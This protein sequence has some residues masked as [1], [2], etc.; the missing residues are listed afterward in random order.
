MSA[1]ERVPGPSTFTVTSIIDPGDGVC[2]A[3][4]CTL[5]EAIEAANV[6]PG[7]EEIVFNIP[8]KW[9]ANGYTYSRPDPYCWAGDDRRLHAAGRLCQHSAELQLA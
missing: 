7:A 3:A 8:G 9:C 1:S 5:R 4:D 2:N 6:S